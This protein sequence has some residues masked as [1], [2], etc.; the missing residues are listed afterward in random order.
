MLSRLNVKFVTQRRLINDP[1][2]PRANL[3]QV[4][5]CEHAV[6]GQVHPPDNVHCLGLS[7]LSSINL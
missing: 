1:F 7:K 2:A 5:L 3:V 6:L 4:L